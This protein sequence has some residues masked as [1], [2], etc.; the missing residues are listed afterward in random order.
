M[1]EGKLF[2]SV[3]CSVAILFLY[4]EGVQLLSHLGEE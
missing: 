2:V 4:L 3:V 1:T